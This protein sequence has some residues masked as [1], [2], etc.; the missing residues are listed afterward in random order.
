MN[1]T[2]HAP[3]GAGRASCRKFTIMLSVIAFVLEV[4]GVATA[5]MCADDGAVVMC[6]GRALTGPGGALTRS[7][8]QYAGVVPAGSYT[9][10]KMYSWR[11]WPAAGP[12]GIG[13]LI[14]CASGHR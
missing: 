12:A 6:G 5:S 2:M 14:R 8:C 10:A 11:C 13:T 1:L 4:I 7:T 9:R 3:V